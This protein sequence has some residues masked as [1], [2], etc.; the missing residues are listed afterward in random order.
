MTDSQDRTS[1]EM[2]NE[3]LLKQ[4]KELLRQ[5]KEQDTIFRRLLIAHWKDKKLVGE[6]NDSI[7]I[8]NETI[9]ILENEIKD[10]D[11]RITKK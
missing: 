5:S 7:K 8:N 2:L 10:R 11:S 6:I 1:E 4:V 3:E 9:D